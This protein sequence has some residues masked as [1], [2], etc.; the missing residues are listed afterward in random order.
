MLVTTFTLQADGSGVTQ[1]LRLS[2]EVTVR[3]QLRIPRAQVDRLTVSTD[4]IYL[5]APDPMAE[6]SDRVLRGSLDG[7]WLWEHA[8]A[9][10]RADGATVN[11]WW[12]ASRDP[13]VA[14][15]AGWMLVQAGP[16]GTRVSL[17]DGAP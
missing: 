9:R 14:T 4:A 2:H 1:V 6:R 16:E 13:L 17:V 10:T 8:L 15:D 3:W 7:R 5:S 12:A 11:L